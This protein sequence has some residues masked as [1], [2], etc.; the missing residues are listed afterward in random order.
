MRWSS[1]SRQKKLE[2][3]VLQQMTVNEENWRTFN[4]EHEKC[5]VD[6]PRCQRFVLEPSDQIVHYIRLTSDVPTGRVFPQQLLLDSPAQSFPFFAVSIG[7][8]QT[9]RI[10]RCVDRY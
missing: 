3:R 10:Y 8:E 1:Y 7:K 5:F 2:N 9:N 4:G 6:F